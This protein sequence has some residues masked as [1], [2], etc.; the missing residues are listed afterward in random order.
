MVCIN[1]F[2]IIKLQRQRF[3]WDKPQIS[4]LLSSYYYGCVFSQIPGGH[5]AHHYG[6]K[7]VVTTFFVCS[8]LGTFL[9]PIAAQT[10]FMLLLAVR[11]VLGLASVSI[12]LR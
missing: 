5:L 2:D 8:M 3:D 11:I 10:H 9:S 12:L 1:N 6:G 4:V 7:H